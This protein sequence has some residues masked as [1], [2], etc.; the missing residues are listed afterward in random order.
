MKRIFIG[1][2]L[3][4]FFP[5]MLSGLTV[6]QGRIRLVLHEDSGRFSL[7][8]LDD[9]E[10]NSYVSLLFQRD[11]RTS[12]TG[13]LL[14]NK[15]ITLGSTKSFE[16]K[17]NK[18]VDGAM[19]SW[20][21]SQIRVEQSF[22]FIKSDPNGLSD[23]ISI[24]I[25]VTNI[26]E[27]IQSVG[28]N[29]LYDT[30]LSENND[31]HFITSEN[32]KIEGEAGYT[33]QMPQYWMTQADNKNFVGLQSVLT[34]TDITVPDKVI[35]SNWKRLSE[36]LWNIQIQSNRNFNLLPYSINDSAVCQYYEPMKISSGA[37][38]TIIAVLGAYTSSPFRFTGDSVPRSGTIDQVL[39]ST[40]KIDSD[41][42]EELI[43]QD[44][45]AI[46]DII[47]NID[48]LLSFPDQ[49]SEERIEI[50]RRALQNLD[51]KKQQYSS[52]Q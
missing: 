11:P 10:K 32:E 14:N 43:Q 34:G 45:I 9:I 41:N 15:M 16:Q 26:S 22:S 27:D 30:Y 28:V 23:G 13:L 4:I 2:Y 44:L 6:E 37:S 1:I 47:S 12:S 18:T 19:F 29:L 17:A 51:V 38:R 5:F 24:Q 25:K 35:F 39:S 36:N 7:Y 21:S 49:I 48:S 33:L 31:Y 20:V 46:N 50:I 3:L 8:Y 42:I 40:S 52:S